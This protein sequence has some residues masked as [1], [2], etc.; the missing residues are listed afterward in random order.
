M[1]FEQK[2]KRR[3]RKE[4]IEGRSIFKYLSCTNPVEISIYIFRCLKIL[5]SSIV[6][7]L[8]QICLASI[9]ISLDV[10]FIYSEYV[11]A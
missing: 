7:I 4:S 6:I 9:T 8:Q 10:I 3:N 11:S 1:R 2:G 5:N